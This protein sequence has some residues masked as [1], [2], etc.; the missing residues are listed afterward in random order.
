LVVGGRS[1]KEG[2]IGEQ[3]GEH[4]GDRSVVLF[5]VLRST[6]AN[7]VEKQDETCTLFDRLLFAVLAV[8]ATVCI[9]KYRRL[10]AVIPHSERSNPWMWRCFNTFTMPSKVFLLLP[11]KDLA[12]SNT[13]HDFKWDS[14]TIKS[15]NCMVG[16]LK[17]NVG[18]IG[19]NL[20][21]E[22]IHSF[23]SFLSSSS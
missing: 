3:C 11:L 13:W 20:C 7:R 6:R 9:H 21:T 14:N 10:C 16:F 1:G 19:A 12:K 5:M 18:T 22:C 17:E 2:R 4:R 8:L 15:F 23:L